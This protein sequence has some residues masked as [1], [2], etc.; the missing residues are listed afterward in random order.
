MGSASAGDRIYR[1]LIEA[2]LDDQDARKASFKARAVGVIT[3]SGAI[4][5][6]LFG[7]AAVTTKADDF[8][9]NDAARRWLGASLGVFL[10]AVLLALAV[11]VPWRL[12][13]YE[14]VNEEDPRRR[15]ADLRVLVEHAAPSAEPEARVED[16]RDVDLEPVA[17]GVFL[18]N[19][20]D[21]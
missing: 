17:S 14:P 1:E 8:K 21:A 6:L 5:T 20:V 4:V 18:P 2:E 13:S 12:Y 15:K 7:L 10:L 16:R 9:L 19:R 3:S 11:N